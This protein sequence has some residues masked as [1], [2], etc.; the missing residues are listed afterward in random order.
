M[1]R[2]LPDPPPAAPSAK[3]AE[4]YKP[5]TMNGPP[6]PPVTP[7][8]YDSINNTVLGILKEILNKNSS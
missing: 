3:S 7:C 2:G 8:K 4:P 5:I 1:G 6:V